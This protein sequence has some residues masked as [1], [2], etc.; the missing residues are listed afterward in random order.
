M[1]NKAN[2]IL[3]R[4]ILWREVLY[5]PTYTIL[6]DYFGQIF[7]IVVIIDRFINLLIIANNIDVDALFDKLLKPFKDK[8]EKSERLAKLGLFTIITT[9]I[10]Y[11]LTLFNNQKLFLIL[12][13]LE[14]ADFIVLKLIDKNFEL[15]KK[16]NK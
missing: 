11:I 13:I 12:I 5:I 8:D 2:E 6:Y 4:F 15:Y 7:W 3:L 16:N 9:P 10:L 14:I 1:G